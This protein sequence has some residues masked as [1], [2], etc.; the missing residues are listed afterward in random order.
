MVAAQLIAEWPPCPGNPTHVFE[1]KVRIYSVV[2][3]RFAVT[4]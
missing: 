2:T 1:Y 4:K 3:G